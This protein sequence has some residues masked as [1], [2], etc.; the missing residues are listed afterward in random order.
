MVDYSSGGKYMV[1]VLS[2]LTSTSM[3][4]HIQLQNNITTN[5]SIKDITL[6]MVLNGANS[7]DK[8]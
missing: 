6:K 2:T 7:H 1:S 5:S 3:Q 8:I 4:C